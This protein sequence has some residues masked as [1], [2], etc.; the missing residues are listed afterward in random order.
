MIVTGAWTLDAPAEYHPPARITDFLAAGEAPVYVGFG[1]MAVDDPETLAR[2][3]MDGLRRAGKRG[4]LSTGY[5]AM[6]DVG[7]DDMLFVGDVPHAWLFPRMSAVV[8]HGGPGTT[9]S[10]LHAGVPQLI[11]PFLSDQPFWG[12]R[13]AEAGVGPAP[14]PIAKFTAA[15]LTAAICRTDDP[16]MRRRAEELG[17][18]ARA[19]P[20]AAGAVAAIHRFLERRAAA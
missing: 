7:G 2:E 16:A 14:V 4:V 1:S 6:A 11:V 15:H 20:G 19:E 13:V 18:V 8:H 10:A 17:R 3:V 5:G 12:H 9:A